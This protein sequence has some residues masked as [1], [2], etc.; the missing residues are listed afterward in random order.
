[1]TLLPSHFVFQ[2]AKLF[3]VRKAALLGI[4]GGSRLSV[5]A[6]AT[7]IYPRCVVAGV[8]VVKA[9]VGLE[10]KTTENNVHVHSSN[11]CLAET[12]DSAALAHRF[13]D[14]KAGEVEKLH[15]SASEVVYISVRAD[16]TIIY[17]LSG[18]VL[19]SDLLNHHRCNCSAKLKWIWLSDQCEENSLVICSFQSHMAFSGVA[20]TG[21]AALTN[22]TN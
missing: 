10:N 6:D 3:K 8:E 20:A 13:P 21:K 11:I 1:M 7:I 17:P 19:P 14:S 16:A 4:R 2:T 12:N 22:P 9:K 18:C 15:C 5:R